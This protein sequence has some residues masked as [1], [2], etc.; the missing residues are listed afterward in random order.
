M[1]D[2]E[3]R[4]PQFLNDTAFALYG[5][6]R[7]SDTLL[8]HLRRDDHKMFRNDTLMPQRGCKSSLDETE[9][10]QWNDISFLSS[11]MPSMTAATYQSYVDEDYMPTRSTVQNS[12]SQ[13]PSSSMQVS[14]VD[15]I[16]ICRKKNR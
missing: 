15:S 5:I 16:A 2:V 9:M 12:F 6:A 13:I 10:G 1:T 4:S 8:D 14:K 11:E 7:K 3:S